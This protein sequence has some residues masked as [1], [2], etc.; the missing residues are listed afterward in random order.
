MENSTDTK[1]IEDAT[2]LIRKRV[3]SSFKPVAY[4]DERLDCIRV[5]T[6]DCSVSE[7][8]VDAFLTLAEDNHPASGANVLDRYVGFTVKCVHE[9]L[10]KPNHPPKSIELGRLLSKIVD[11][12][13]KRME[14][15]EARKLVEVA[16]NL[17]LSIMQKATQLNT[18]VSLKVA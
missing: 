7:I 18:E 3:T 17:A 10:H 5:I 16:L 4:Y 9:I 11:D 8:R 12:L 15:T 14:N 1:E 2:A 13:P 6:R